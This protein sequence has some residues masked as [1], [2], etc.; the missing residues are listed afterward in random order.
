[1]NVSKAIVKVDIAKSLGAQYA[2]MVEA[3]R[4]DE[5][6]QE[7]ARDALK[8]AAVRLGELGAHVDKDFEEGKISPEDLRDPKAIEAYIKRY[9]KRVVGVV[10]SLAT[11]AEVAR[12]R[13]AGRANGLEAAEDVVRKLGEGEAHK[14][15]ELERQ[16]AAG[17][18]DEADLDGREAPPSLKH[19]RQD[20]ETQEKPKE[21]PKKKAAPKR[22]R[23]KAA[24]KK[25]R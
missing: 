17:E 18:I 1:M 4:A 20:E 8:L 14:L 16:L 12:Y 10:D 21:P 15:Q 22:Q 13:A 6:R 25:K 5:R 19:Q 3:A 2:E 9:V 24:P 11:A 7:G 23:K